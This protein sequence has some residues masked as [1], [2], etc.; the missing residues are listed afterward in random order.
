MADPH[1][2]L[3]PPATAEELRLAAKLRRALDEGGGEG[4][5]EAGEL[6][7]ALKAAWDA[8][9]IDAEEHD[10]LVERVL[11][12]TMASRQ[13]LQRAAELRRALE[14][15]G[16]P[17]EEAD[18]ARALKAAW[19]PEPIEP[20]EHERIVERATA[21]LARR[22]VL[23]RVSFGAGAALALA[24]AV[25][26]VIG[27]LGMGSAPTAAVSPSPSPAADLAQSRSTQPLFDKPFERGAASAR[28]DRIALARAGDLRENRFAMWGV[29]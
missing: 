20:R 6:A 27:R 28:I 15:E 14:D 11:E 24:A 17:G 25:L 23:V 4:G 13:E 2:E 19:T 26:F 29:R 16:V 5:N 18:L 21:R 12:R 10:A 3:D 8:E 7:R 1:D 22:G 9:P